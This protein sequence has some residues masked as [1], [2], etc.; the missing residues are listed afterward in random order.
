MQSVATAGIS[1]KAD[2]EAA[3]HGTAAAAAAAR[4]WWVESSLAR[5]M[6]QSMPPASQAIGA[7]AAVSL[8]GNEHESF[9]VRRGLGLKCGGCQCPRARAQT[10]MHTFTAGRIARCSQAF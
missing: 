8:A 1:L 10:N 5:V 7:A 6:P 4:M 3:A 2:D 9:Q